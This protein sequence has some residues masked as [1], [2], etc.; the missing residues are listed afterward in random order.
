M[1]TIIVI[2]GGV[3]LIITAIVSYRQM[4]KDFDEALKQKNRKGEK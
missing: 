2:L 1:E 4:C 3:F